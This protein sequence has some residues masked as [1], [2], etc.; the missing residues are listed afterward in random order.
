MS[1]ALTLPTAVQGLLDRGAHLIV[2]VSGG[3]DSDCMLKLLW[4][5]SQRHRWTGDFRV[6]TCDLGR[7]EWD[8]SLPHIRQFVRETTRQAAT[9]LHR[10][11]GDLL[12]QWWTRYRTLQAEG[13]ADQVP[14]WSSAAAR[15]CT[16]AQK[17]QQVNKFIIQQYP[18]DAI[19]ISCIGLRADESPA[20][21]NKADF[22]AYERSPT[23]PTKNRLVY[24]WLPIHQF[25]LD[26]VWRTLGWSLERLQ[27]LQADVQA[28]VQPGDRDGLLALLAHH[29]FPANP[30][31]AL[32]NDRCSCQ[33]CVLA[34]QNDIV[35]GIIW[36]PEHYRDVV[37][38][39]IES[40]FSFQPKHFLGSLRPDLL[41]P[42]QRQSIET[43]QEM[44][45]SHQS[46]PKQLALF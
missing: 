25:S 42:D 5:A 19:I 35:N 28:T 44:R 3:K 10:P 38:L 9:I 33:L 27:A 11:Q 23:A 29:R 7:N 34:N 31:Y 39:E 1:R 45:R 13:R 6:V 24:R 4:Q 40:G 8:F 41:H 18:S 22:Q 15:F 16:K 26:D 2:N 43:L 32:G 17:E 30:V 12:E 37:D 14:P 46:Q 21:R 20:R 36:N